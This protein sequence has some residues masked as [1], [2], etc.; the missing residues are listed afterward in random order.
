VTPGC[1]PR[2]PDA[3]VRGRCLKNRPWAYRTSGLKGC[4][5]DQTWASWCSRLPTLRLNDRRWGLA[6]VV[7]RSGKA[8]LLPFSTALEPTPQVYRNNSVI[9]R[10]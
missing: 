10:I 3:K 4:A 5:W 9:Q 6:L 1:R 8:G 7:Q 2:A